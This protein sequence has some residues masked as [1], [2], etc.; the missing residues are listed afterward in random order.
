MSSALPRP[1][2]SR[3]QGSVEATSS[4]LVASLNP[5][6]WIDVVMA[7]PDPVAVKAAVIDE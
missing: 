7:A 1:V 6:L 5:Q 4:G 2:S 3:S